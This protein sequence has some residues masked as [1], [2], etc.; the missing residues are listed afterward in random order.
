MLLH[1]GIANLFSDAIHIEY[2][3]HV[4]PHYSHWY[5]LSSL[6]CFDIVAVIV[7]MIKHYSKDRY[8]LTSAHL[9]ILIICIATIIT[10]VSLTP[11][12]RTWWIILLTK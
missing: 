8:K 9:P 2:T 3:Q 4:S 5:L 10:F 12:N 1:H 7:P 11:A 6:P